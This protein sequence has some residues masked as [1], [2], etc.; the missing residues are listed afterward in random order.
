[1][2]GPVPKR[3]EER[4]RRNKE[5]QPEVATVTPISTEAPRADANWHPRAK[6]LYESLVRSGQAQFYEPSDWE[7]AAV[8]CEMLSRQLEGDKPNANMFAV[9]MSI[10]TSLLATEGD[11]RRA[12]LILEHAEDAE[13]PPA[14]A[15]MAKYRKAASAS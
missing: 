14:V 1:M 10:M 15:L 13:A 2:P 9:V 3:P 7:M 5:S 8:A 12:R 11:R 4:R 6:A